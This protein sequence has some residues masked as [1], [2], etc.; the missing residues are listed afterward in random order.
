MPSYTFACPECP[1]TTTR[2]KG[3]TQRD[4]DP[5]VCVAHKIKVRMI[6]VPDAPNFSVKGFSAK[7]GYAAD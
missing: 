1:Y 5:P 7:N 6:R 4:D 2:F 3:M